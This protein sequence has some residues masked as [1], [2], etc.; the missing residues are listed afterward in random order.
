MADRCV[1]LVAASRVAE[2][3]DMTIVLSQRIRLYRLARP[4]TRLVDAVGDVEISHP[5]F[6]GKNLFLVVQISVPPCV[7]YAYPQ[8]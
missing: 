4:R 8:F 1:K 6:P 7:L 3:D 5:V 2:P